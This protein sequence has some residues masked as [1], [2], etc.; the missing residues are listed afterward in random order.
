MENTN[1]FALSLEFAELMGLNHSM[2]TVCPK[3]NFPTFHLFDVFGIQEVN[4][5][6]CGYKYVVKYKKGKE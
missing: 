6:E 2:Y 1:V 3:C 5:C 4:K